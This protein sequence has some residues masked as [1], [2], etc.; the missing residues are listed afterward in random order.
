MV[1]FS[2]SRFLWY[3]LGLLALRYSIVFDSVFVV[4]YS[5]PYIT[6]ELYLAL[7]WLIPFNRF[8]Y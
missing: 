4:V 5:A 8:C 1:F 7:S 2:I 6:V 3:H